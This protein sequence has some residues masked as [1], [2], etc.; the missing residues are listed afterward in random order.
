MLDRAFPRVLAYHTPAGELT[1]QAA[2]AAAVELNP[3]TESETTKPTKFHERSGIPVLV[4]STQ[5][6]SRETAQGLLISCGFVT[7]VVPSPESG[8]NRKATG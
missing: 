8:L 7:F 3:K 1:G 4:R 5:L 6:R 2:P